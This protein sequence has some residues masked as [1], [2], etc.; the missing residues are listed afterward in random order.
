[1]SWHRKHLP[2]TLSRV[3]RRMQR[4]C[5]V[6]V[7]CSKPYTH[8]MTGVNNKHTCTYLLLISERVK[9]KQN[10]VTVFAAILTSFQHVWFL[11]IYTGVQYNTATDGTSTFFCPIPFIVFALLLIPPSCWEL[12][13]GVTYHSRLFLPSSTRV[14]FTPLFVLS[15]CCLFRLVSRCFRTQVR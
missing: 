15:S 3:T 13:P 12:R 9:T 1:M 14:R 10:K 8:F 5:P 7:C 2:G 11:S 4:E 6:R